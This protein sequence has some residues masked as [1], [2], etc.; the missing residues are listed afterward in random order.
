MP[1]QR[2]GKYGGF[3]TFHQF[4]K[5]RQKLQTLLES[6][7]AEISNIPVVAS[8]QIQGRSSGGIPVSIQELV[9]ASK[10]AGVGTSYK[11]WIGTRNSYLHY[12]I[13]NELP[14]QYIAIRD[15]SLL[16]LNNNDLNNR[17]IS[18]NAEGET[19]FN[20][21]DLPGLE[22]FPTFSGEGEYNNKELMKAIDMV[23]EGFN[24]LDE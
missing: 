20:F 14:T 8:E 5:V 11:L 23:K 22:E 6:P 16:D 3:Q 2:R 7:E 24:I 12:L 19:A 17:T 10:A 18:R 9:Y 21:K 15:R 13:E 1:S 4:P